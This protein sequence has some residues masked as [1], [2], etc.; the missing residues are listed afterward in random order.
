MWERRG[1][2]VPE[3]WYRLPIFY[4][5]NVSEMRGPDDPIWSPAASQELDYEL[6]VA[7]VV[8]TPGARPAAR[9]GRGGDRR[10]HDLQRLVGARPPARGDGRPARAGQ[11]QGLRELVRAVAGH[12]RRAGRCPRRDR[13]RPRDDGRGERHRDEP[14]PLV[15]RAVLV[16]RDARPRIRRRAAAARRPDRQRRRSGRAACSRSATRRSVAT[17]N[18]ATRSSCG[19]SVS[20]P[21][22][23][24]IVARAREPATLRHEAR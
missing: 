12:A 1:G 19:S 10:L 7:A 9:A 20:A 2:E 8:D 11:G 22:A 23:I 3:A 5:S 6:E 13:L 4:F 16:R 18:R 17:S 15:R 14:R 21:C 24:P